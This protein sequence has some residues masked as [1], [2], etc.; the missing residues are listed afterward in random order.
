MEVCLVYDAALRTKNT[1]RMHD[2]SKNMIEARVRIAAAQEVIVAV[3]LR[4]RMAKMP[5]WRQVPEDLREIAFVRRLDEETWTTSSV[6]HADLPLVSFVLEQAP[7]DVSKMFED[8]AD[9]R[10]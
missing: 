10:A 7:A 8:L 3:E 5:I 4:R 2:D 9:A 6:V 1:W